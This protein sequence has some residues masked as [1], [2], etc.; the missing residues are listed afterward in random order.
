MTTKTRQ[1]VDKVT[2][3][4]RAQKGTRHAKQGETTMIWRGKELE[5]VPFALCGMVGFSM[6]D[7]EVPAS[8]VTCRACRKELGLN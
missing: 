1:N 7:E 4:Y 3:L 8:R 2:T 5:K 6:E